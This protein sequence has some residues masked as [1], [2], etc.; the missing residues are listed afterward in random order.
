MIYRARPP[1]LSFLV[2]FRSK[3][4]ALLGLRLCS[5][6]MCTR[7]RDCSR[8]AC[9]HILCSGIHCF[10]HAV[11]SVWIHRQ[12]D[13]TDSGKRCQTYVL[14]CSDRA[15]VPSP[16]QLTY[17]RY[18]CLALQTPQHCGNVPAVSASR[19]NAR[20]LIHK[21]GGHVDDDYYRTVLTQPVWTTMPSQENQPFC[22]G[23]QTAFWLNLISVMQLR[24]I[25]R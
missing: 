23:W 25:T 17:R 11:S 18:G 6:S 8:R 13:N 12:R 10:A 19:L 16:R 7:R 5:E 24:G 3:R 15:S 20:F 22:T 1:A 14:L 2:L 9:G 4:L 21:A